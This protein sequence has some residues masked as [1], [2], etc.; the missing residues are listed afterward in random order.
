MDEELVPG[1][2]E[3]TV[4]KRTRIISLVVEDRHMGLVHLLRRPVD[5]SGLELLNIV[6]DADVEFAIVFDFEVDFCG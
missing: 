3:P 1:A 6:L 2:L 4:S 5:P